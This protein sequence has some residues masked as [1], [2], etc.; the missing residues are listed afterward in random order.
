MAI[1][2]TPIVDDDG[3]GTTG[4][5]IDNAWKQELYTQID[6]A[7]AAILQPTY[8]SWT[9]GDASGAGLVLTVAGAAYCKV[10]RLVWVM[11]HLI[12][13]ATANS[14]PA[15]V[16]GL[17]FIAV[18][19]IHGGLYQGFGTPSFNGWIQ[20]GGAAINLLNATTGA[21]LSNAQMSGANF[22]FHGSYLTT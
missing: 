22:T 9:P 21:T 2:R 18:A 13:P 11:A 19:G 12:Y 1:I 16:G 17:P 14:A 4:T 8:G 5:V 10:G 20:S 15:I 3:S 7:L 6:V